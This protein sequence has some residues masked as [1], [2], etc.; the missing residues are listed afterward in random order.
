MTSQRIAGPLGA[1]ALTM[2]PLCLACTSV[3][4]ETLPGGSLDPNL[5][6]K[7]VMPLVI[8]PVLYDDKG[9]G[10]PLDVEVAQ[11]QIRQRMLPVRDLNGRRLRQTPLWAYGNPDDPATFNH[12]S[13]TI[14]VTKDT[15]TKVKWINDLVRENGRYLPHIL[16]DADG[17]PLI[18]QTL[19]WA[20]PN[21]D[22]L[23][24]V[25]RT[26]CRGASA[27]PY[28]GPIP[29]VVHVHGAHVGPGSDG[30]PEA[31]WLPNAT[32][33]DCINVEGYPRTRRT[34]DDFDC[35]GT[36]FE[37]GEGADTELALGEGYALD[38]YP[39]DQPS[40]TL[41]YH[42]H[43]LGITRLN[44]YAAG[45]GF[46]LIREEDDGETGLLSGTL[47]GPAPQLGE[48]PNC[49]GGGDD[50]VDADSPVVESAT[51]NQIS[52]GGL[53]LSVTVSGYDGIEWVQGER[54]GT[55][56]QLRNAITTDLYGYPRGLDESGTSVTYNVNADTWP[57]VPCAIQA[58]DWDVENPAFG[59]WV[60]VDTSGVPGFQCTGPI[61]PEARCVREKIRE[62]PIA[63][64]DKS[65]NEDGTLFYPA[66]RAFF[67]GL[68]TGDLYADNTDVNIP[69]LPDSASDIA[70]VWNPE[71]FF[72]TMVVNG[73]VWPQLE[74]A[75]ER[76]RLR[77]L[78]ATNSRFLNLALFIVLDDGADGIPGT[79]D[80]TLGD[81]LAFYQ[82][83]AEQSL[84]PKVTKVW[85]GCKTWLGQG[86]DAFDINNPPAPPASTDQGCPVT[87]FGNWDADDPAEA[88]LIG[89][90]ERAD[91]IVD[92]SGLPDG[93]VVRMVNTA[94]DAPFGGFPDMAAD[95][96]TTGQVMQFVIDS[97]LATPGGDPSTP[98]ADLRLSR[99]DDA[100]WLEV[101]QEA[102][103]TRDLALLEEESALLC[104][105]IDAVT[106]A[107]ELDPNSLPPDCDPDLG[108]VPFGPK[109]AVLGI[110][111]RA[112]GTVQLW[113]DP[114]EQTVALNTSEKW[115]LWNWS[116]DAHPIHMHLVKFRVMSR[117]TIGGD[118][119]GAELTESGW[120]DTVIAYPGEVTTVAAK[121]DITGLYVWHCHILEHEDNEMMV[122][123]CVG[124]PGVD[125]PIELF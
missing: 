102:V 97:A 48:D 61:P 38:I 83:G 119:E 89:P 4:G 37:S 1:P 60:E 25:P 72:N 23:D 80:D 49:I 113:D 88:L 41:W 105:T 20:A 46:W 33:I 66:D 5:I 40:T 106:G 19:H 24:G 6:P 73:S 74:A 39:N 10:K 110:D 7:Y 16:K 118:F 99:P 94:P 77:L 57:E 115:Q 81:E 98:P 108:S 71:A 21:Q 17:N 3:L 28:S 87:T 116:A 69:F 43:T 52:T 47:P 121:F 64:Q 92:L 107:I 79:A 122:P 44:V 18:D 62:I 13:Y 59:P 50:N 34:S 51:L 103:Q 85:T 32:N 14:E 31:W 70:P 9:G 95:P 26:D 91:V 123:F 45:A 114:I 104:V 36:F 56:L 86:Q 84:L 125:C 101:A 55:R 65:F 78:N 117:Q 76:Y 67:E 54:T 15:T 42:D 112:G 27:A 109:A 63:L 82:I 12:P 29:M 58:A 2:L 124:E 11:R 35:N 68:G 96:G 93:T 53:R 30:Y 111:G 100:K 90:A 8:P 22:C 75:P 120:K